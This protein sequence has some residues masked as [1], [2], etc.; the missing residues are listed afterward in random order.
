MKNEELLADAIG[1]LDEELLASVSRKRDMDSTNR[2]VV[3]KNETETVKKRSFRKFWLPLSACLVL[4]LALA[5]AGAT[6]LV[7]GLRISENDEG[8]K[9]VE[10]VPDAYECVPLSELT[11]DVVNTP[12]RMKQRLL[13]YL[14]GEQPSLEGMEGMCY[15][16]STGQI[17]YIGEVTDTYPVFSFNVGMPGELF[18]S[19]STID[20]AEAYIGYAGMHMPRISKPTVQLGVYSAGATEGGYRAVNAD[21][22]FELILTGVFAA[23]RIGEMGSAVSGAVIQFG[24]NYQHGP[25]TFKNSQDRSMAQETVT[26]GT[27]TFSVLR[28]APEF[29]GGCECVTVFWDENKVQYTLEVAYA[30]EDEAAA[31]ALITEWMNAF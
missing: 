16:D 2:F 19:F 25:I 10:Y 30:S 29:E 3:V 14:A 15:E 6:A 20:A 5:A 4:L 7:R 21:S 27:R 8:E 31:Q 12:A 22:E 24:D 11:G 26:V 18:Q 23:Y 17:R 1:G 9:M 28:I 13:Q